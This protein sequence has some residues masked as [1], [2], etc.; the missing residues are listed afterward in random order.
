M[1]LIELA[2]EVQRL[3]FPNEKKPFTVDALLRRLLSKKGVLF[4]AKQRSQPR[5]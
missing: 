3:Y 5:I 4:T 1:T 2:W